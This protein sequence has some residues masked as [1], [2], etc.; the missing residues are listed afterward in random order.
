MFRISDLR[1]KDVINEND[2]S[3]LGFVYDIEIDINTGKIEAVILPG[4]SRF[5][6]FFVRSEEIVLPWEKIK[7]IGLDVIIIG[8]EASKPIIAQ[9]LPV[10]REDADIPKPAVYDWEDWEL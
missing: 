2:G 9:P 1:R 3:K 7:K 8:D 5:L 10:L 6:G 4:E